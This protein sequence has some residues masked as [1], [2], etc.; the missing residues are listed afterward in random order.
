MNDLHGLVRGFLQSLG[1]KI[2]ADQRDCVIADRLTWGGD[3]ETRIIW[4]EPQGEDTAAYVSRL[5]PQIRKLRENYPGAA[6]SVVAHNLEGFSRDF[7]SDL[8]DWRVNLFVPIQFFDA[9][10]KS[11]TAGE[12]FSAT[13]QLRSPKIL[14]ERV[15]QPYRTIGHSGE[16]TGGD[17][18]LDRLLGEIRDAKSA[19]VHIVV[20]SAGIGKSFLFRALFAKLYDDFQQAKRRHGRCPRPAPLLP[21]HRKQAYAPRIAAVVDSFIRNEVEPLIDR[22]SFEWLL[23]NGFMC[24][25]TDGLDELY[26]GDP[27]FFDYLSD[28]LSRPESKAQ[29]VVCCR[30]SLLTTSEHFREFRELWQSEPNQVKLYRLQEW[31]RPSKRHFA[32][33]RLHGKPPTPRDAEPAQVTGFLQSIDK[34]PSLRSL[35]GLPFYC[36]VLL[37]LY[38]AGTLRDFKNDLELVDYVV[39]EMIERE[40]KK[41]ILDLRVFEHNGL[42]EWLQQTAVDFI[43]GGLGNMKRDALEDYARMVFREGIDETKQNETILTLLRFPLFRQAAENN[44]LSFTHELIAE[45]LAASWYLRRLTQ[46]PTEVGQRLG[47][48]TDI[49]NSIILRHMATGLTEDQANKVIEVLRTSGAPKAAFRNLLSLLLLARPERDLVQR[50]GKRFEALDLT[51]VQFDNRDL[52]GFSFR[53]SELS[54][55]VFKNCDLKGSFFEG[56][57]LSDTTYEGIND[58]RDAHFGDLGRIESV[59]V[60]KRFLTSP[61]QLKEWIEHSTGRPEPVEESCPTALQME[62]LFRK[63][64]TPLGEARRDQLGFRGLIAGRRFPGAASTEE[65]LEAAARD[66]YLTGPDDRDRYRRAEGDRYA[67]MMRFVRDRSVS[68]GLGHV[69]SRLCRRRGCPH[70][71]R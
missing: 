17:E 6:A 37:D 61:E 34:S 44:L 35:S 69:L 50:V 19:C 66:G 71:L 4:T 39:K 12:G 52:A 60:G 27:D 48:R 62:H 57:R 67:E 26:S 49:D 7:R 47:N 53:N 33:L 9:P 10:F 28:L 54:G 31:E 2:I 23:V 5:A 55:T 45:S 70:Q 13:S 25:L 32:W 15:P 46:E 56:A 22:E 43:E 18:L 64:I 24:W 20:G 1:L 14:G 40:T 38:C 11:D 21:E 58:L 68:S 51:G 63:F 3:R 30:D 59:Y 42:E 36:Q 8:K 29:L 41:G 16:T 65:C